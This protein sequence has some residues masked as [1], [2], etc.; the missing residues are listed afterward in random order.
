MDEGFLGLMTL[1]VGCLMGFIIALM[2]ISIT[3]FEPFKAQAIERGYALHCPTDG[4]WA[5]K[6]ECTK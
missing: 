1:L 2:A 4:E 3:H 5:W 6:G